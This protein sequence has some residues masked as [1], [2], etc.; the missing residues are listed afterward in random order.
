[1][2]T[3]FFDV[4]HDTTNEHF[5][6]VVTNCVH[7]NFCRIFKEAVNQNRTFRGQSAFLAQTSIAGHLFHCALQCIKVVND[8][9]RTSTQHVAR[10]NQH[11]ESN[12]RCNDF[13]FINCD[14]SATRRLRNREFIAQLVPLLTVFRKVDGV[15][16]CSSNESRINETRQFQWSLS[17]ETDDDLWCHPT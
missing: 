2:N 15:R 16:R 5:A 4:L 3:C 1:M 6:G 7:I 13:C 11:W 12:T 10:A 17:A 14:C 8:L 9:H